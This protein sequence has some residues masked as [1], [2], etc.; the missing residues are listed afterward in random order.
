MSQLHIGALSAILAEN[1][2]LA[3][4]R[5]SQV[6]PLSRRTTWLRFQL[7][8]ILMLRTN[9][10]FLERYQWYYI[11]AHPPSNYNARNEWV[12]VHH[13]SSAQFRTALARFTP[14]GGRHVKNRDMHARFCRRF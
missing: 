13:D 5:T 3:H 10:N 4:R 11:Y 1:T 8:R 12:F 14:F 2:E 9:Q 7:P 6:Y